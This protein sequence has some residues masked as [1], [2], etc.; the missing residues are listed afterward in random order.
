MVHLPSSLKPGSL[1]HYSHTPTVTLVA[2]IKS[3]SLFTIAGL[4]LNWH[5]ILD[6]GG[7]GRMETDLVSIATGSW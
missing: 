1:R 5:A 4:L 2:M 3:C 6:V 7:L